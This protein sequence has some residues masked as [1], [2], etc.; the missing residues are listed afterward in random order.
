MDN[1]LDVAYYVISKYE[2]V[3]PL[4]LQ[5]LLYYLKAWGLVAGENLF[6]GEFKKWVHGPVNLEVYHKFKEFKKDPIKLPKSIKM[7]IP[8]K[9]DQKATA[10]FILACYAQFPAVTLSAMTHS[11]EPWIQATENGTISHKSLKAYYSKL[12]FAKN[13]PFDP[14]NKPFYPVPTDTLYAYIFDMNPKDAAST[15]VYPSYKVY[16]KKQK[17]A[18]EELQNLLK[19]FDRK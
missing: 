4:K 10:D 17:D 2:Q 16:R 15:S 19:H 7:K 18:N 11:E 14:V 5:K 9:G 6:D 1:T 12:S 13:F 8:F 3:T